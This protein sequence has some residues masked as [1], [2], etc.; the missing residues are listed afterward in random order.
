M[1]QIMVCAVLGAAASSA[2]GGLIVDPAFGGDADFL[3]LTNNGTLEEAVAE[4]RIGNAMGNGTWETAIWEQGGVDIPQAQ[5]QLTVN[6]GLGYD[7]VVSYDGV[8]ELTYTVDQTTIS[9]DSLGGPF[10]DIFFRTRSVADATVSLTSLSIFHDGGPTAL[11]DI[12]NSG[13]GVGYVRLTNMGSDF[14][15]F[16]ITGIQT[17]SWTGD[18]PSNSALAYQIKLTNVVP[19]PGAAAGLGV[20]ALG[21]RRR[22]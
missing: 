9:W 7:F 15:A 11:A 18:A 3:A 8:S 13:G 1:R 10:T 4:G 21:L 5:G 6:N 19:A 2:M 14:G 12:V 22:R 20:L 16:T 17:L